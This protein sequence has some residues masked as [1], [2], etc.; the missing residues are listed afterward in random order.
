MMDGKEELVMYLIVRM[1]AAMDI[2]KIQKH[3]NVNLDGILQTLL[4]N[5]TTFIAQKSIQCVKNAL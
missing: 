5:V 2:V 1:G 3:V 4:T